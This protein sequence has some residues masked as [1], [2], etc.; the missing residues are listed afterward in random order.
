MT[1]TAVELFN[2]IISDAIDCTT[3]PK[4]TQYASMTTAYAQRCIIALL[5]ENKLYTFNGRYIV[6]KFGR[7][8]FIYINKKKDL[9]NVGTHSPIGNSVGCM[10]V[11]EPEE[12]VRIDLAFSPKHICGGMYKSGD[13]KRISDRFV[14]NQVLSAIADF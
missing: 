2:E 12:T 1:R 10:E 4:F 7:L 13:L 14:L 11:Q 5:Q 6:K 9:P 3:I 8:N